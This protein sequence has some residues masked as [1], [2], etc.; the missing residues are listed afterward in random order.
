MKEKRAWPIYRHFLSAGHDFDQDAR[1][2]PLEPITHNGSACSESASA[3]FVSYADKLLE[4]RKTYHRLSH[5]L[6]QASHHKQFIENCLEDDLI[7]ECLQI[8]LEPWLLKP[9][10]KTS[11][12]KKLA[13]MSKSL[14]QTLADHYLA[15]ISGLVTEIDKVQWQLEHPPFSPT[16]QE[17][18]VHKMI[19]K[20]TE[21]NLS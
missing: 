17:L 8:N 20:K 3:G 19:L 13:A 2:L 9:T 21:D 1:I 5:Q 12:I 15:V 11:G 10:S 14:L 16:P 4:L 7:P 18:Q 6:T